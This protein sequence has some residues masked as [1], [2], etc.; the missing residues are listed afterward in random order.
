M[1]SNLITVIS[2]NPTTLLDE[3]SWYKIESFSSTAYFQDMMKNEFSSVDYDALDKKEFEKK[4]IC[5]LIK[6]TF[7]ISRM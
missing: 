6:M 5:V 1:P 7:I 3:D 4:I 2:Y